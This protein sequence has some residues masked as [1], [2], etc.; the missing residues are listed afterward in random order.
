MHTTKRRQPRL[1]V[2][3]RR[4]HV[5]AQVDDVAPEDM[6]KTR[7]VI[8]R[9]AAEES[10]SRVLNRGA[11]EATEPPLWLDALSAVGPAAVHAEQAML[12][13][14]GAGQRLSVMWGLD[15]KV[16]PVLYGL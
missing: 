6:S 2:C 16:C 1:D 10:V 4:A 7:Q 15:I 5:C 13:S 14:Q 12:T 8:A 11:A 9:C 3:S